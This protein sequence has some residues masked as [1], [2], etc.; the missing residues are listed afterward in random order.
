M[1]QN[2]KI[3]E[4]KSTNE[5]K[6]LENTNIQQ[7]SVVRIRR[8]NG[9]VVQDCDVYIGRRQTMGKQRLAAPPQQLSNIFYIL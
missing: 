1:S 8:K 9:V 3:L 4:K 5:T 7:T 2:E 6:T